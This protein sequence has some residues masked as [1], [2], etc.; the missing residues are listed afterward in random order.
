MLVLHKSLNHVS[1]TSDYCPGIVSLLLFFKEVPDSVWEV[2]LGFFYHTG[3]NE[4]FTTLLSIVYN[5][6]I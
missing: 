5:L 3:Q 6:I 2:F 4:T 1:T